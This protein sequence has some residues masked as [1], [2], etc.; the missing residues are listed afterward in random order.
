MIRREEIQHRMQRKMLYRVKW[1]IFCLVVAT[2]CEAC[3]HVTLLITLSVLA[4]RTFSCYSVIMAFT[5]WKAFM[6]V[7]TKV[8]RNSCCTLPHM[9]IVIQILLFW[10]GRDYE[11]LHLLWTNY[12]LVRPK[13]TLGDSEKTQIN[14]IWCIFDT[15]QFADALLI[16][17]IAPRSL[18]QYGIY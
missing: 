4:L 12:Y 10:P 7:Q 1:D 3:C 16:C 14:L 15:I 9:C 11:M 5:Y 13:G 2:N 8:E 18:I 6:G 17:Y